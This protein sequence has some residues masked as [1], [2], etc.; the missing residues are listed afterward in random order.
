MHYAE[1]HCKTNFSFLE[2]ASHPDE[3]VRR[4]AE[5]S[6][7]ALAVTDRN[8]LA[9]VVRAHIAAKEVGLPLVIGAEITPLDAPPVVLWA[10]DRASYGRLCR[11]ITRG[12]RQ[13]TKGECALL[14]SDIAEFGQ[15][16]IAGV[17]TGGWGL[18]AGDSR[19][20]EGIIRG[21]WSV[22]RS[23]YATDNGQRTT[24]ISS[25]KP[26]APSPHL[27]TYRE[28][29]A[30]RCYLL[31]ELVRGADDRARLAELQTMARATGIP[32]V[33]AG[34]VHYHVPARMVLHDVLTAIRHRTTVA[35]AEGTLLFPNAE[36]H[37]RPLNDIRALFAE[38]P[39]TIARTI[40]IA[41]RCHFSLDELRYEYPT[42]LAQQGLGAGGL[43]LGE[44]KN[45][46][47]RGK[48][49]KTNLQSETCQQ[50][51]TG[52]QPP[53]SSPQS[54]F[55]YLTQLTW[56]GAAERYPGG[57]P[58]KVRH[59]IEYELELVRDLHYESY[60]LTVWDLVRFARSKNILCQ[61]RGSAANS[62]VCFCLGV[63]SVDPSA[64]DLLFER[65][66]SRE[67]NEAP[68]IDIDFEHERREEVLQYVYKKYGR[69]RAGLAATVITYCSRS[70]IRDVGKALGL[71]LDRVDVLAKHVEGYT[72]EPKLAGRAREVGVDPASE[73][74]RR[75]IYCVNEIIGFPRHL[76]QHVGGMV[77]TQGPLC[78]MVPIE[79]AAMEDRTVIE[80]DKDDL[81]ELGILKVDCL[82]LGM[83]TVIHKC[84]D[85]VREH[86]GRELTLATVPKDDSAVYDM[87]CRADTIG[88][89]QIESRAQM[90]ML[91]RL[92]PRRFYDLVIEV[93]IVRPGPIQGNMVHPY[94][95]RRAGEEPEAYPNDAIRHVLEKTLG[96]P[97]FQE[98][99]MRLAVVAAGF[100]PGEADQLR[101]AMAAWRRPGLIEQFRQKLLAGM[102][103]NNLPEEFAQRVYQQI[104]GFGEY[105]FPE[106]HAASFALLVYASAWLKHH[107]PAAFAAAMVNSQPMG[108]Y[109]PAQLV[110]DARDHG[111]AVRPVDVN[112]SGWGCTL[113]VGAGG[114]GLGAGDGRESKVDSR[115]PEDI[116][117]GPW[118]VVR[119]ENATDNG[120]RTTGILAPSPQPPAPSLRLGLRMIGGLR[121]VHGKLIEQVRHTSG[122]F[123]S[124]DN[125]ARR[126][127][128]GQAVIKRLAEADAFG[129][130]GAGRRQA[131]WHAL[132]QEKK[133]R[134]MPLFAPEEKEDCKMQNEKRKLPNAEHAS[135]INNFQFA[136]FNLQSSVAPALPPMQLYEEVVA[137]YRTA[138]LS[139]RAHPISFYRDQLDRL[140]ITPASRLVELKND[141]PVRVAGLVLLRQRPGTA[142]GITFVTLEDETGTVN[143]VVHQHMWDRYY[144]IARRAP[145]WIAHGH[146]QTTTESFAP[147]I[148]V[149]VARLEALAEQ[150]H[151]LDVKARDFR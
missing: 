19:E 44:I 83:L 121:E 33:A 126:T 60:F 148:H 20:P 76:S 66:L 150:L 96:V 5:L 110:R 82:C 103:A 38:A 13:A 22:V 97:I 91:P 53:V 111:V 113:E 16:L 139:L 4:A 80:W 46:E 114:W 105:G 138:G 2:G 71:S 77:M 144:A 87:I 134:A 1:L 49:Q 17:G 26:L 9:G 151:Q 73:L 94:L 63:T 112:F 3:L 132:G 125:F 35:A 107:Y 6:Y 101:R 34:D 69:E 95:R 41:D 27:F 12:R 57:V 56:Q 81:D 135:E 24:D 23:S 36:R 133:R 14:L 21:P 54:P 28:I 143:L 68:D 89:F 62:A 64:C 58:E 117:R 74:G 116:V 75:L 147:V 37:L 72:H 119:G 136:I 128:L 146:I 45:R 120:Q 48:S 85:L 145:A 47:S 86:H 61:G 11:L 31:A 123:T 78:E 109:Q 70:A 90:S 127:G 102:R 104:E 79:N 42:E 55:E 59:Q 115:E 32:L 99:A 142:K 92:K 8:S 10:T 130:V 106:S 18:E 100:T 149:V 137:D 140:G 67:R 52:P 84:F 50:Q 15:G 39:E 40:E 141:A 131:L 7:R 43:G 108:F 124:I 118:S 122:P 98:Q 25:P 30:D 29:F 51:S 93:A 129:S 65:F 88:V